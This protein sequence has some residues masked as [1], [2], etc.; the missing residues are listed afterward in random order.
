[1]D[2]GNLG[3][4]KALL[5]PLR[6]GRLEA[7][8]HDVFPQVVNYCKNLAIFWEATSRYDP[9]KSR[10]DLGLEDNLLLAYFEIILF[11]VVCRDNRLHEKIYEGTG[12]NT[13]Q[14]KGLSILQMA[15]NIARGAQAIVNL[16][17]Y[18]S[19][20]DYKESNLKTLVYNFDID[21]LILDRNE[22]IKLLGYQEQLHQINFQLTRYLMESPHYR[23]INFR[24]IA[25]LLQEILPNG[26][27]NNNLKC[28]KYLKEYLKYMRD[29][30]NSIYTI[31]KTKELN[32]SN[33]MCCVGS[34]H[35]TDLKSELIKRDV[36]VTVSNFFD[37]LKGKILNVE[38][39]KIIKRYLIGN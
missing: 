34:A 12:E 25:G 19:F 33:F 39:N 10:L 1:M 17:E 28:G 2:C 11:T 24:L 20:V 9:N 30:S 26:D 32:I 21:Q 16:R 35:I 22:P 37:D 31:Q 13:S 8:F 15:S 3:D 38:L 18:F 5:I 4:P 23:F 7:E 36:M 6:H 27:F 14:F 29:I